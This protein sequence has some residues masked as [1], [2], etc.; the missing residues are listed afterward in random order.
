M[1]TKIN[2]NKDRTG[3][4]R[5]I[6]FGPIDSDTYLDFNDSVKPLL[7][8]VT[9]GIVLDL[10]NVDYISSAGLGVLFTMKKFMKNNGGELLFCN[11]KPQIV[12]LF[13]IVNA[14]PKETLFKDA[15]EA[16]AY[17]YRMMNK[18]TE[19]GKTTG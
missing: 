5:V 4:F 6:P 8:P 16:D 12:R 13:E 7:I 9:K 18:P 19:D 14:L 17:L 11:M 2:A 1:Q 15:D 10:T 3:F